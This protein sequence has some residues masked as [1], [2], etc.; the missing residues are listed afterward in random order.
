METLQCNISGAITDN[1]LSNKKAWKV[2]KEKFPSQFFHECVSHGFHLLV[3]D[4]FLATK[5]VHPRGSGN[6]ASYPDDSPFEDLLEFVLS[7]KEVVTFFHNHYVLKAKLKAALESAK[8]KALVTM[9][10]IRWRTIQG[11]LQS[12]LDADNVLNSIASEQNFVSGTT[13]QKKKRQEIKDILTSP[14]YQA[15][16]ENCLVILK[17]IDKWIKFFQSDQAEVSIV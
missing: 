3:K 4:I 16:L 12:L 6:P 7:C 2:L 11:L 17:P 8:L 5:T 9:A 1:T 13:K 14:D 15:D 10:L